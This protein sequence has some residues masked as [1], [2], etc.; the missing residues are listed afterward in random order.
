MGTDKQNVFDFPE[1]NRLKEEGMAQARSPEYR[2]HTLEMARKAAYHAGMDDYYGA[3]GGITAD[4]VWRRMQLQGDD[5]EILGKAWGSVWRGPYAQH[6][7]P[8]GTT[9]KSARKTNHAR[10]QAVWMWQP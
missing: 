4:T 9:R 1:G 3:K 6:F 7:V 2:A 8:T 5:P 10:P